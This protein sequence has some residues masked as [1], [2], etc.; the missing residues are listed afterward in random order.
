MLEE[1]VVGALDV[2]HLELNWLEA[3][4]LGGA[5]EDIQPDL[6]NGGAGMARHDAVEGGVGLLEL[7]LRDAQLDHSV[8]V[9]EVDTAASINEDP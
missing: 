4:I 7:G 6:P 8:V 3:E 1:R 9:E 2:N 5:K